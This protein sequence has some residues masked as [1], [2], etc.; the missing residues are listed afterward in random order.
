MKKILNLLIFLSFSFFSFSQVYKASEA[1]IKVKGAD[2][3]RFKDFSELPNFIHFRDSESIEKAKS[4]ELTKS[5]FKNND[6]NLVEKNVQKNKNDDETHRFYQVYN[7]IPIEFTSWNLQVKNGKVFA[8]NGDLFDNVNIVSNFEISDNQAFQLALKYV[9]AE[10]YMW[11]DS[12]EENLLKTFLKDETATYFPKAE[13]VLTPSKPKLENSSL[14]SAY[15]FDIYSKKPHLRKEV[16]VDATSGEILFALSKLQ[17]S[18]EIGTAYT[19]YSGTQQINTEYVNNQYILNDNTRGNG[20]RTLNCYDTDDYDNAD[21]FFDNDNFWNNVNPQLDQYATDAHFAT[22][23]TYDYYWNIHGRN[24]IDNYGHEL[25]SFVHFSLIDYGYANNVNAFWNGYWMTYGD[26]NETVTPLTTVD[27][28]AHEITHGLTSYTANLVYQDEPGA[29]NEAFSDIF[30]TAVEFYAKPG[31]ANY[32]IGSE[33]GYTM[34][35]IADPNSTNKPDTYKGNYWV[36]DDSDYGGVHTNGIPLCYGFYLLSEGGS[37]TNDLGNSYNVSA[38][39]MNKAEQIFFRLLTVYL[40]ETSNYQDA[41]FYAMQAAADLYGVCSAEVQ[42]VGDMFYAIG[43]APEPY[44]NEVHAGFTAFYTQNCDAPFA[45]KFINQSYNADSFLWDFGDGQT[46]NQVNPIHTY[47]ISG[48]FDV[49]LTIDGGTCGFDEE[50]K[51]NFVEIDPSLPCITIFPSSGHTTISK[52]SGIIYDTGGPDGKYLTN[53]NS[54]LTIYA[55]GAESIILNILEFDIEEGS[56][57]YCDYDYIAFYDGSSTS[58]ELINGTYYCNTAGNPEII[59][60]T[61]PYITIHFYSDPGLALDGFKIQFDCIGADNPPIPYFYA[62]NTYSCDGNIEFVDNS[63]NNPQTWNWDFGDGNSSN[64]ENPVHKYSNSGIYTVSLEVGN[65][66]GSQVATKT[67]YIKIDLP[68]ASELN[69]VENICID[70][71]FLIEQNADGIL[72]WYDSHE[73]EMPI[74]VGNIW[75]HEAIAEPV[76]YWVDE[77]FAGEIYNLGSNNY[78]SNGAFFGNPSYIHYLIFDAFQPFVLKTVKINAQ[79]AGE[80]NIALRKANQEIIAQKTVYCVN[81]VQVINLDFNVPEGSDLQLVGLG[82]PNLFR[83]DGNVNY[84]YEIEGLVSIKSS[85]AGADSQDYYYFF[86]DW[87]IQTYDCVSERVEFE[88]IPEICSDIKN[89]NLDNLSIFPNP[90]TGIYSFINSENL[91]FNFQITDISGSTL[92]KGNSQQKEFDISHFANGIYFIKISSELG[93][94][95]VKLL[96]Q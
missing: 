47:N 23:S 52:C 16:Y 93:N 13:K 84:P 83:N 56:D 55:E 61:G 8:L 17:E 18:D 3:L 40:S 63:L 72:K 89:I 20:I 21:D 90:S 53:T 7:S 85:S 12:G 76:T 1:D 59:Y 39:G 62:E 64:E 25:W 96:K 10:I 29:L 65:E 73:S 34:R 80:R 42:S 14:H 41:W 48:Y 86:Y 6:L 22:A 32:L 26:G 94:K 50:I 60:S 43:V 57:Y 49:K 66:N 27:I 37:G 82:S 75:Q 46:S 36:H 54:S 71:S 35:S 5:F 70:E 31:N 78:N 2:I 69:P 95:F 68:L 9:D 24:S 91:E 81:G 44:V 45:V 15:K 88:I 79:G 58:S 77:F 28:C 33:I 38:L 51:E 19:Q 67:D 4:I 74:F 87:K 11:E 30:G 92:L